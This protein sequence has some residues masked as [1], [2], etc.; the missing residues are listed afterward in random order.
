MSGSAPEYLRSTIP[1]GQ[2]LFAH[3]FLDSGN[4]VLLHRGFVDV[5]GGSVMWDGSMGVVV[6][7]GR[8]IPLLAADLSGVGTAMTDSVTARPELQTAEDIGEI[9]PIGASHLAD[10]VLVVHFTPLD[11]TLAIRLDVQS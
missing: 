10:G 3:C 9:A 8:G 1:A 4:E 5:G 2:S 7:D 6:V 11:P